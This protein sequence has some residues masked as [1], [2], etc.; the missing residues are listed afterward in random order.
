LPSERSPVNRVP[1]VLLIIAGLLLVCAIG[2]WAVGNA[3]ASSL[4][5]G[6][7]GG[8]L[9]GGLEGKGGVLAFL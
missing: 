4:C 6:G 3:R 9:L 2:V 5:T 7:Q 8:D 1:M